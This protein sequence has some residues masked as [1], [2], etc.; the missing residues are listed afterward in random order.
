M[1][2]MVAGGNRPWEPPNPVKVEKRASVALR[3]EADPMPSARALGA[4]RISPG[5][6]EAIDR[7]LRLNDGERVRGC[8][9]L[10]ELL[11]GEGEGAAK[12]AVGPEPREVPQVPV[13]KRK[14]HAG[15]KNA[16][17]G[18]LAAGVAAAVFLVW[19]WL[20][21]W[22]GADPAGVDAEP[23]SRAG[24]ERSSVSD[25]SEAESRQANREVSGGVAEEVAGVE[26][27]DSPG[28]DLDRD[29]QDAQPRMDL[30]GQEPEA[31]RTKEAAEAAWD[32][33][34]GSENPEV[35]AAFIAK[36]ERTDGAADF[37]GKAQN[38]MADLTNI[39]ASRE[40]REAESASEYANLMQSGSLLAEYIAEWENVPEAAEFVSA[41]R[42]R[43]SD[44]AEAWERVKGTQGEE[45]LATYIAQWEHVTEAAEFVNEARDHLHGPAK[46]QAVKDG[47]DSGLLR[48]LAEGYLERVKRMQSEQALAAYIAQWEHVPEVAEFV[49]EARDRLHG[50]AKSQAVKKKEDSGLL[51]PGR[52]FQD[53][54]VCP[55]MV[56]LPAGDFIM[57]S[58]RSEKGRDGD[59]GPQHRVMIPAPFA[60]GVYEVTF[61]EWEACILGGGCRRNPSAE[62]W[63][64][65]RRPVIHMSWLDTQEYI[66]WLSH[67][68]GRPYRLLSEA[69]WEYAARAGTQTRYSVGN[70][71]SREQAN[72]DPDST[73]IL[74]KTDPVGLYPPNQFGLHD[75]HGN[76]WEWVQDCWNG[77]YKGAPDK[78][79]AWLSGN[80]SRRVLRGGSW[81][82]GPGNLRSA[83]RYRGLVGA[84]VESGRRGFRVASTLYP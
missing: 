6:L 30:Q 21:S 82:S 11:Q 19:F 10:L 70:S 84:R 31:S 12:Q 13:L 47:G 7:C 42:N 37:V 2:R 46:S 75:M 53:C 68:T 64:R 8:G 80:C 69:E 77:S 16:L 57:G 26:Q 50:L 29:E 5:I 24:A 40:K 54:A 44:L 55:Q 72:Y 83:D 3:G 52:R 18:L 1:W 56:V 38:R 61:E 33:V 79:Q 9:E 48:D 63:G 35:L 15:N 74:G 41:A 76:V 59:E 4:G 67:R 27:T 20:A 43:L 73:R 71:I 81:F 36:W 32:E 23:S 62:G 14:V 34:K 49:N 17:R 65:G 25:G 22:G 66:A 28:K 58:P 78:G 60:V 51:S 45:V 39:R